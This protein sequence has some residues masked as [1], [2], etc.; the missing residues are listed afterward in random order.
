MELK[1]KTALV[2]GGA[3]RVGRAISLALAEQGM[4]L[5]VHYNASSDAADELVAAIRADGG[6]AVTLGADLADAVAVERLAGDAVA[7][8]G[9]LDVLVNSAATFPSQSLDDTDA[10]LL[11]H[12]L[13]VN[14]KA[15]FLLTRHLAPALRASRGAVVNMADLAGLQTWDG[16]AAHGVAKAG[17]VHLTQVAARALAP[18]VRVN[19]IAPGTVLPPDSMDDDEVRRLAERAP[20]RR[21]GSPDDVVQAML[22]LLRAD[23]VTGQVLVVDGGRILRN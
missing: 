13:A 22:Y 8:F 9:G 17:V 21:N 20:L 18:E 12:T 1:G 16:Y 7:A 6:E 4:R 15:P 5:V 3:V 14:L 10:A 2:T 11:E 19:A 23:F